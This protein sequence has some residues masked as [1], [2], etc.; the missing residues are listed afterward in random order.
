MSEFPK[1][2]KASVVAVIQEAPCIYTLKLKLVGA[3]DRSQYQFVPGQYNIISLPYYGNLPI[4][5]VSDPEDTAELSHTI[6]VVNPAT[7]ALVQLVV[8][9][10]VEI[11]GPFGCGWPMGLAR[12]KDLLIV[13]GGLGCAPVVS[14]INYAFERRAHYENLTI[15]QG[16]KHSNDLIWRA[17]YES[18]QEKSGVEVFLAADQSG[19][20]WPF[21]TG[22]ITELLDQ[23]KLSPDNAL[24]F[25]CGPH[26]MMKTVAEM[27]I[28]R[29]VAAYSI[30]LSFEQSVNCQNATCHCEYCRIGADFICHD[31]PVFVYPDV[32]KVLHHCC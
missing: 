7:E 12:D 10:E 1:R 19:P 26:G 13:T 15:V 18:W 29:G 22:R 32:Q 17:Q 25:I 9:Q 31:G 27:L 28:E 21:H 2:M 16:V 3:S 30:Y 5:I 14:A 4:S 23:V 6:R 20:S 8:G 24:A 11:E